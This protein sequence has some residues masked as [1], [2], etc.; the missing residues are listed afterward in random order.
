MTIHQAIASRGCGCD[1]HD[2][3]HSL[4]SIDEALARIA[5]HAGPV[6][7]TEAVPLANAA[8]RILAQP[9]RSRSMAPAFDNA[10]MDGYA[11]ARSALTGAG[12]WVLPVVARVPAGQAVTTS[13]A[14]GG[15][16]RIFTGA[17][18]PHGADAVV[19]QEDVLRDG[20]VIHLSRRPEPGLNIRRAG[21]DMAKGAT[22]LDKGRRLG[23]R[24]IAACASAGAGILRVRRRLRVALLVTG[25]E[26]RRAGGARSA[27]QIWDVNTPML[28]AG[29]AAAGVDLVAT[30]HGADDLPGLVRQ[31]SDMTAQADL[32]ITTGGISVGEE[33]HVKP[34]VMALGGE[35]LFS[36]VAIKPG[37]PVSVGRIG[38]AH[39]LGLPGNPVSA[40]VTWQ[41][42]GLALVRALTGEGASTPTRRHVVTATAIHRKPGRCELRPA[43]L[44][45]FD[46]HGREVVEFEETTHSARVGLL[47]LADGLMFLPADAESLPAGALVEF[48]P[49]CQS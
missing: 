49:F 28:T 45:G 38:K 23:P 39:W 30:A 5:A 13:V 18:I 12:P 10:A 35:V 15:A 11:I 44:A 36:G 41:V 34:A 33:D 21:S 3:L 20:S 7:R 46:A 26:V 24:D 17:P 32:V 31:L 37:K 19:M 9:V 1:R 16:A 22:A 27:A 29:L 47:S 43:T 14:G 25:D 4:I 8:G 48:Q 40:F 42:F 6:G 2:M